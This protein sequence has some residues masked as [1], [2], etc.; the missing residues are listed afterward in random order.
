MTDP[1]TATSR[2]KLLKVSA[3]SVAA[4]AMVGRGGTALGAPPPAPDLATYKPQ[5][6]S[7]DEW[8][9]LLAAC[10]RLIPED[11]TG[12]G[13]LAANVPIF[14]DRQMGSDF[15]H[16][17]DWY[18]Q[19]PFAEDPSPLMGYQSPLTPAEVY[20]LGIEATDTLCRNR[21]GTAF[22]DA[23]PDQRD[24]ILE[25]LRTGAIA[26]DGVSGKAFFEFLLQNTKEGFFADPLHGGNK[27]MIGWAMLGFPGARGAYREWVD[28]H[29]T[30]YPLGPVSL[31]GERR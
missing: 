5:A 4:A 19:G 9:F 20:H 26:L 28:Q 12:P 2:R 22:A 3:T 17:R 29:D 13:A 7:P 14:I 10:D 18:M 1:R 23:T 6:F 24:A 31:S 30:P 27:H 16:A 15:G 21:H 25:G 11:E 8:R